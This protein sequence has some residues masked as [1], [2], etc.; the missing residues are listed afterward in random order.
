M[1]HFLSEEGGGEH[2]VSCNYIYV[3]LHS[4]CH[5]KFCPTCHIVNHY[6]RLNAGYEL[7]RHGGGFY[8][9]FIF[10]RPCDRCVCLF[11]TGD[12]DIS[13]PVFSGCFQSILIGRCGGAGDRMS[14]VGRRLLWR[15][16]PPLFFSFFKRAG[17]CPKV[18]ECL[19][20]PSCSSSHPPLFVF[21][22]VWDQRRRWK[23][24]LRF[25]RVAS[26]KLLQQAGGGEEKKKIKIPFWLVSISCSVL[27]Q[28]TL[29][30]D[31]RVI[32]SARTPDSDGP[33][34]CLWRLL[35]DAVFFINILMISSPLHSLVSGTNRYSPPKKRL[36]QSGWTFHAACTSTALRTTIPLLG[37]IS[38]SPR[39]CSAVKSTFGLSYMRSAAPSTK[40]THVRPTCL[41]QLLHLSRKSLVWRSPECCTLRF[42]CE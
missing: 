25:W 42:V 9:L 13:Q 35:P 2:H 29:V 26:F 7:K 39:E 10:L 11:V 8:F 5:S 6:G 30:T 31:E 23:V 16:I 37:L 41:K 14:N 1:L 12:H 17:G 32:G 20:K 22:F 36:V 33:Y 3:G 27:K 18:E 24:R 21:L 34:A 4:I 38:L 40:T 15:K 19:R 28:E